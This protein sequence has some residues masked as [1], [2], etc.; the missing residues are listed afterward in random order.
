[1]ILK[2]I[3]GKIYLTLAAGLI[4]SGIFTTGSGQPN[5]RTETEEHSATAV[6]VKSYTP[7]A[8]PDAR[9]SIKNFN[10][11][12]RFDSGG[13]GEFLDVVFDID[14][15]TQDEMN[16]FVYVLAFY[17]TDAVIRTG[18]NYVPYPTWRN[19]DPDA[20]NFL[21]HYIS[22]SPAD[23][24]DDKIWNE[25]DPDFWR[26][27]KIHERITNHATTL[28]N[29]PVFHPPYWKYLAYIYANKSSG[30]P[31]KLFG[32]KSPSEEESFST[33]YVAPTAEEMKKKM[34]PGVVN[35]KYTINY[36]K[37]KTF[38]QTHHHSPFRP[39]YVFFNRVAV[40][41]YDADKIKKAEEQSGR[42]LKPGEDKI[43]SM[44]FKRTFTVPKNL[45]N[46]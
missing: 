40:I 13:L 29:V 14:N 39:K 35:H 34:H 37:R 17:E 16:F 33:N 7:I 18:G 24:T 22:I 8:T 45:K 25:E 44:V 11:V 10:F 38:V 19:Y 31:V 28:E 26:F 32:N 41:I 20:Y 1:M 21:T 9:F 46:I 4:I 5:I 27:K 23:V 43:E 42:E 3:S 15:N 2:N 36:A 12:R 30:L 6:N